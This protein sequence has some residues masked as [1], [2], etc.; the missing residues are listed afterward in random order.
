MSPAAALFTATGT[1]VFHR[2]QKPYVTLKPEQKQLKRNYYEDNTRNRPN[3]EGYFAN[4]RRF[5]SLYEDKHST[6]V[7]PENYE[8]FSVVGNGLG[9]E[10]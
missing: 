6:N 2:S 10:R 3:A 4:Y 1:F 9:K 7:A 8:A 5:N